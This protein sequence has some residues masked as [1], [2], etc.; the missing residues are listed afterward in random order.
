MHLEVM[1]ITDLSGRRSVT[2]AEFVITC[3]L[4][5]ITICSVMHHHIEWMTPGNEVIIKTGL[6]AICDLLPVLRWKFED[7]ICTH[8]HPRLL[9]IGSDGSGP[10]SSPE[11]CL[12]MVMVSLISGGEIRVGL[13]SA[14]CKAGGNKIKSR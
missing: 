14:S 10:K 12:K 5:Y 9:D 7:Y 13:L 1:H 3:R 11:G 6:K 8:S 4:N 2:C